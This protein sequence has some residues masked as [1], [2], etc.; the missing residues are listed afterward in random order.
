MGKKY[1]ILLT[2]LLIASGCIGQPASDTQPEG[3]E[4]LGIDRFMEVKDLEFS[5]V[6]GDAVLPLVI[7]DFS[8]SVRVRT[9]IWDFPDSRQGVNDGVVFIVAEY[10]NES[11]AQGKAEKMFQRFENSTKSIIPPIVT[12]TKELEGRRIYIVQIGTGDTTY[13][14]SLGPYVL[15]ARQINGERFGLDVLAKESFDIFESMQ[16]Q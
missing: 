4:G 7:E 10:L 14:W 5:G 2:I 15:L 13:Y 1:P 9:A 16:K 3:Q 8:D 11:E 12:G 6:T